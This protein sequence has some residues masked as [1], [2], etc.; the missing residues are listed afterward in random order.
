M[1]GARDAS[2]PRTGGISRLVEHCE[3]LNRVTAAEH[4]TARSRL[5]SLLGSEL[6]GR[7]V[8]ALAGG[9]RGGAGIVLFC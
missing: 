7:L 3:V 6:A 2:G 9:R 1:H 8:G 5:E 4:A